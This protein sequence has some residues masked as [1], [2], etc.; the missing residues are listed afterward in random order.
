MAKAR[1]EMDPS[2]LWGVE[3]LYNNFDT[4]KQDFELVQPEL[5]SLTAFKGKLDT[6]LATFLKAY[7][8][9]NQKLESLYV[10]AHLRHDEDT[11]L[12]EHKA[13]FQQ[14]VMLYHGFSAE[15]AWV[16]PEILQIDGLKASDYP[17]YENFL[18]QLLHTRPHVLTKE[19]E[20]IMA[21]AGDCFYSINSAFSSINN[22]DLKFDPALD[23]N[24]KEHEVTHASYQLLIKDEDRTLRKNAFLSIHRKF[25]EFQNT[26]GD[27]LGGSVKK[28]LFNAKMRGY[29][30]CLDAALY[31]NNIDTQVYS[32]LIESVRAHLPAIHNYIALRKEWLKLDEIHAYDMYVPMIKDVDLKF[33]YDEAVDII[34]K[35]VE[36]LGIEYN[37]ILK[38]GMT[39]DR[40]VDRYENE[41]KRSGAYSCSAYTSKPYILMNYKGTL[42][43]V[44]TL[45]HE[46]GHSMHSYHSNM[47]QP[48]Q[49]ASYTIFVA[50]VASTFHEELT[51]R[52]L[53]ANAKSKEEKI[54]I[55]NQ[56][57]DGIRATLVRQTMFAEF[58]LAIHTMAEQGQ[59]LTSGTMKTV[60][61]KLNRDYF[62]EGFTFDEELFYEYLR[63]PHF[64]SNFYVYQYATGISAAYALVEKVLRDGPDDYIRFL[65]SGCSDFPVQL[66]KNAGVD[67]SKKE[68]VEALITRFGELVDELK[69]LHNN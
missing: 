16:E 39:T 28:H 41:N 63:I 17:E 43:D 56:K 10:Y 2:D 33:S 45:S 37:A 23:S 15:M 18:H 7:F 68:P 69:H 46:A 27:L 40:W 35:A 30:T 34:L 24:G 51:F 52:Y 62:G 42:N 67:V 25:S 9:L 64:Y 14:V 38:K 47:H 21:S 26:I 53:Y 20:K 60:F 13:L 22:A 29:E 6:E 11:A 32:S 4:W 3:T 1:S 65:S 5:P 49:D 54:Y 58:E 12:D 61:E 8:E 57:I 44:M 55:L 50:E 59:P 48:F 31:P 36:P 19:Q 66:L